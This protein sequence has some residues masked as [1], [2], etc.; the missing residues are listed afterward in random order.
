[1]TILAAP[2]LLDRVRARAADPALLDLLDPAADERTWLRLGADDD[3]E[4]WLIGWPPGA[5]TDWHDHGPAS[6]AF[7]VLDGELTEHTFPGGL[8]LVSHRDGGGRDFPAGHAHDVRNEGAV[9]AL[10]LHG[11]SPRLTTMTRFRFHGDR[12]EAL[13]VESAG[14][15]W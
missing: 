15:T 3:L 14:E 13:G 8:Q 1:M 10:S 7:V 6:G 9:P 2:N 11:Y 4:L 5:R 12:L